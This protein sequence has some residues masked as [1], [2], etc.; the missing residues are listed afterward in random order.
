M[1]WYVAGG[2]LVYFF[3]RLLFVLVCN[4]GVFGK[5]L[6]RQHAICGLCYLTWL[7]LGFFNIYFSLVNHLYY[8]TLLGILG[9]TLAVTAAYG[10]PS[11][12]RV[13]NIA[14]GVLEQDKTV[15]YSEMI[16][17]SFYQALNL[18]QIL[19]LHALATQSDTKIKIAFLCLATAPWL[20]RQ[21][22]PVNKFSD[23]YTQNNDGTLIAIL[24]R[25]KKYQYVFY[26]HWLLHGLN[27]T[28]ALNPELGMSHLASPTL[29][30]VLHRAP[31]PFTFAFLMS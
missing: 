26:K 21:Q 18:V 9:T 10:F 17:H 2:G 5:K 25:L 20:I 16:E 24:Y 27:I 28:A 7:I 12:Q 13:S 23:N 14:S 31:L 19:F 6:G 22:F 30:F 8:D 4:P 1:F 29:L 3:S 11:H 15:T